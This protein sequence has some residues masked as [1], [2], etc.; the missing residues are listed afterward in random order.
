[1]I[2][3]RKL[4]PNQQRDESV[5][6][7]LRRSVW[8][9][10]PMAFLIFL[11]YAFG[12]IGFVLLALPG[13][14]LLSEPLRNVAVIAFSLY[15]LF[16]GLFFFVAFFDFYFD[17]HILTSRRLVDIDQNRLFSRNISELWLEDV[18][19]VRVNQNGIMETIFNFGDLEVQTAGTKPNFILQKIPF[20]QEVSSLIIDL[21]NQAKEGVLPIDRMP[22]RSLKGIIENKLIYHDG[23]LRQ[24]GALASSFPLSKEEES[25][26]S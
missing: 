5:F 16:C 10:L 3:F 20:P 23:V 7:F 2:N 18:Q 13:I 1:M 19:D 25:Q 9:F 4:L 21:A 12:V 11:I 8:N 14:T 22:H 6:I 24:L 15:F 26:R 17:I